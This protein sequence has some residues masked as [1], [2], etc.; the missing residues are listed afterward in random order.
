VLPAGGVTPPSSGPRRYV[1]AEGMIR[2]IKN[3]N[4]NILFLVSIIIPP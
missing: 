1:Q 3:I 4:I 2:N